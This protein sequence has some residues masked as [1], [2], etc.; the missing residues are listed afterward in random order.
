MA[1]AEK[2]G[3]AEGVVLGVLEGLVG[4]G[5]QVQLT[6]VTVADDYKVSSQAIGVERI[7]IVAWEWAVFQVV[8]QVCVPGCCGCQ[9]E[10]PSWCR[11]PMR[12]QISSY[13]VDGPPRYNSPCALD[14]LGLSQPVSPMITTGMVG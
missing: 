13:C 12:W 3:D 2:L 6:V 14:L 4:H 11:S 10:R 9:Q 8:P 1:A 5:E 7:V